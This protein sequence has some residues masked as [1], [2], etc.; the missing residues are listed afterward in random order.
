MSGTIRQEEKKWFNQLKAFWFAANHN[1][2][3][4]RIMGDVNILYIKCIAILSYC[5]FRRGSR[6]TQL[7]YVIRMA[8]QGAPSLPWMSMGRQMS[9]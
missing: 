1:R 7:H 3:Y 8:R 5:V 6:N 4:I 9:W 2:Y